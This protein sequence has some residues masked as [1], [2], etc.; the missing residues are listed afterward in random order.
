MKPTTLLF[1]TL[2]LVLAAA[3]TEPSNIVSPTVI[4][5]LQ[6]QYHE[7]TDMFE[8]PTVD[9]MLN[10]GYSHRANRKAE[11]IGGLPM[12]EL[13]AWLEGSGYGLLLYGA[14]G[15]GSET[16][17]ETFA[18]SGDGQSKW[19]WLV[20]G[21]YLTPQQMGAYV[22]QNPA[23][24]YWF[25]TFTTQYTDNEP[26][27]CDV[28]IISSCYGASSGDFN[29]S[30]KV[31]P[32][33]SAGNITLANNFNCL[34]AHLTYPEYKTFTL[35][36]D[37]CR[38]ENPTGYK[39][40][41]SNGDWQLFTF[42]N[43]AASVNAFIP[44][45][46]RGRV[47][48]DVDFMS[49]RGTEV[50]WVERA[51]GVVVGDTVRVAML[52]GHTFSLVDPTGTAASRYRL[53]EREYD[54]DILIQADEGVTTRKP[55]VQSEPVI[56]KRA[57]ALAGEIGLPKTTA[58]APTGLVI[59]PDAFTAT[60]QIYANFWTAAGKRVDVVPLSVSGTT[61]TALHSYIGQRYAEGVRYILLAGSAD[62]HLWFDDPSKWPDLPGTQ[63]WRYWYDDYHTPGG[64]YY[65]VSQPA[66]D[67]IPMWYVADTQYDN[68]SYWTPYYTTDYYY[69]SDF[70]GLR[71]GRVPVYTDARF[72]A[73][74]NKNIEYCQSG[75]VAAWTD[76]VSTWGQC[77][78]LNGNSGAMMLAMI[79]EFRGHIPG[80][81]TQ[82]ALIDVGWTQEERQTLAL[83]DWNAG[84]GII[85][86]LG[87]SSTPYKPVDFFSKAA[88]WNVGQLTANKYPVVVGTCCGIGT[89]DMAINPTYGDHFST[90]VLTGSSARGTSFVIGPS[91]GTWAEGN[92]QMAEKL[93]EHI[94]VTPALDLGTAFMMAQDEVISDGE[95]Q[96]VSTGLSF[97]LLGDPLAPLPGH[98]VTTA[99]ESRPHWPTS[100]LQN[101]PNPF[102]P[103][104]TFRF[105][106]SARQHVVLR[107]YNVAGQKVATVVD[108]VQGPGLHEVVWEPS[109]LASGV[110][111]YQLQTS[112]FSATRKMILLK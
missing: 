45:I 95:P 81:L 13:G 26:A 84:R 80:T 112:S 20:D 87:T 52:T 54:G 12:E 39:Y 23:R 102:N 31:A 50:L 18:T 5:E 44:S 62:E 98:A 91:R 70:P 71:I 83:A 94:S 72:L 47:T 108:N 69:R 19:Q 105:T 77:R 103:E 79:E 74:V 21:Q 57:A 33:S 43:V 8:D 40:A 75:S 63:D 17:G 78:N 58:T 41:V 11:A 64:T 30:C 67:L 104:T 16:G 14:H 32:S 56:G 10:R 59:C 9:Q 93:N 4:L 15:A 2:A 96:S 100:L 7:L 51:D 48:I 6:P 55:I 86:M 101:H 28:G 110:Y 92:R 76:E 29:A 25:L 85:Y 60:A 88:G 82:H 38:R 89:H 66:R 111:F 97:Q 22:Y 107:V 37:A 35:A 24:T 53:F 65:L 36:D 73:W 68:M 106:L 27:G 109:G 46:C 42:P 49:L 61:T 99:T 1:V 34:L 90:E 3:R